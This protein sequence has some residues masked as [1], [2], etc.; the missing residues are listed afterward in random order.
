MSDAIR[1]RGQLHAALHEANRNYME[2]RAVNEQLRAAL[3]EAVLQ[4][5][6]LHRKFRETGSGNAVI[7]RAR[8]A[9][10]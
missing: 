5:E 6:Y 4:L 3:N 7:A 1:E 2:L 9:L 10:K 8:E